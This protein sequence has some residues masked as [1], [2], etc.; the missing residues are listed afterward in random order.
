[1]LKVGMFTSGY[2]RNPLEHCFMDAKEYGYDYIELWGGRPHAYAPDLKAGDINEV[3][4]LIEKYEMP[5]LGYTPEHNAYPYNY[6]NCWIFNRN[7]RW[8]FYRRGNGK[9]CSKCN[10]NIKVF[11]SMVTKK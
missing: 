3:R 5:V 2:Q 8:T 6:M 1:M 9:R 11:W 7:C 10:R 4:R